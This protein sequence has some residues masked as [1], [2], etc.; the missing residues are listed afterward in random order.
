MQE[1]LEAIYE[2]AERNK[3][4]FNEKFEQM[5]HGELKE[6][7]IDPYITPTGNEIQI[8][9]TVKDLGILA[10]NDLKFRE[11]IEKVTTQCK[12]M[13]GSLLRSFNTQDK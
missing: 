4:K 1:D 13:M 11:H 5:V 3:M 6:I 9:N 8:K 2:W 10:T 12:I 7:A